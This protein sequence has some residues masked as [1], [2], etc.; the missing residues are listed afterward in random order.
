MN[1]DNLKIMMHKILSTGLRTQPLLNIHCPVFF[2]Q[3]YK[4]AE[5]DPAA[6]VGCQ[7]I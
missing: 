2:L 6:H 4:C 7:F 3:V 1:P 5:T